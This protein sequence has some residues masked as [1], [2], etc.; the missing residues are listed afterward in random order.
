LA[1]ANSPWSDS[2]HRFWEARFTVGA[3]SR[4]LTLSVHGWVHDGLMPVFCLLVGLEIKREILVGELSSRRSATLPVAAA[5]G[6]MI[7]PAV[8]YVAINAGGPGAS[9]W[10]MP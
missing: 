10:G 7:V 4:G 3:L 6:G 9:G 2:Y 1:W 8:F 5:F